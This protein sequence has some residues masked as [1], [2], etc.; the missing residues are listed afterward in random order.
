MSGILFGR[1]AD[2]A[3]RE[4]YHRR[5]TA[6]VADPAL[7]ILADVSVG[8]ALPRCILPLG[9]PATVDAQAQTITFGGA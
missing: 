5:L 3:F 4:E 1:P 6:A 2:N 7:P 9:V 8:H